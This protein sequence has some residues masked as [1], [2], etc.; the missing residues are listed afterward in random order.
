MCK[1]MFLARVRFMHLIKT[2]DPSYKYVAKH[3]RI[4]IGK[5]VYRLT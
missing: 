2:V 4:T 3:S 5:R 1:A